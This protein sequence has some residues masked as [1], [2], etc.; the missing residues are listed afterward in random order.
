MK[1]LKPFFLPGAVGLLLLLSSCAAIPDY[2]P[3]PE[4]LGTNHY[5][6]FIRLGLSNGS[7]LQ[8][9]LLAVNDS[10]LYLMEYWPKDTVLYVP[11]EQVL[12]YR[13]L[14]AEGD[15][16]R[17][18]YLGAVLLS[19]SHGAFS[20]ISLPVNILSVALVQQYRKWPYT[21]KNKNSRWAEL[22]TYARFPMGW[23]AEVPLEALKGPE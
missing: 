7:R 16:Y 15:D 8:G 5:G 22:R 13:L 4:E 2:L 18:A 23:P 14:Y 1:S 9:E 3:H 20:V 11:R 12:R 10:S 6:A 19:A 21:L 17:L